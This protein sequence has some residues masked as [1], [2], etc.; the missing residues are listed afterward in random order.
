MYKL[1]SQ[2]LHTV[3]ALS[4]I[5]QA[6]RDAADPGVQRRTRAEARAFIA[7]SPML[8][9]WCEVANIDPRFMKD[10][11]ARFFRTQFYVASGP[12]HDS[13]GSPLRAKRCRKP[14]RSSVRAAHSGPSR[15]VTF[16]L[17]P[18]TPRHA[19]APNPG[20]E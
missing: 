20:F 19:A 9:E 11:S 2:V 17:A 12:A 5:L 6:F 16:A 15:T 1:P 18:R 3:L 4:V 8:A 14:A 7:D 13:V 10:L